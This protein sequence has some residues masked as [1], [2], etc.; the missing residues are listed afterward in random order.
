MAERIFPSTRYCKHES[1]NELK[2]KIQI[3]KIIKKEVD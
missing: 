1:A 2:N 3:K